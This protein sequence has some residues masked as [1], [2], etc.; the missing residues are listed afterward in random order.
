MKSSKKQ[1]IAPQVK[2]LSVIEA[3]QKLDLKPESKNESALPL[4]GLVLKTN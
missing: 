1:Y 2:K 3:A 4:P